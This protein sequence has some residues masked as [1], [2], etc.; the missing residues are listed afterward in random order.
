MTDELCPTCGVGRVRLTEHATYE[1]SYGVLPVIIAGPITLPTCGHCGEEL[2]GPEDH[3]R[4]V[5][6][7]E[8]AYREALR[9]R[10][11]TLLERLT[12]QGLR[13]GD[14]ERL[15]GL[16]LGSATKWREDVTPDAVLVAALAL[17]AG[18]PET[19]RRE[20]ETYWNE[21]GTPS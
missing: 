10:A 20:L 14:V 2:T 8:P 15:L 5:A 21:G 7:L 1:S 3:E 18:H 13:L 12:A 19:R 4:L 11:M 16:P 6:V 9:Q 17:L